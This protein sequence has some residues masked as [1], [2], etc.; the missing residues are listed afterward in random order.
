MR[1]WVDEREESFH[2]KAKR[3]RIWV[4][5]VFN[6]TEGADAIAVFPLDP[7]VV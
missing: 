5:E 6:F 1:I 7:R 4:D 3:T 2:L